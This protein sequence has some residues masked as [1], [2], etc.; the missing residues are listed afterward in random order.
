MPKPLK[1]NVLAPSVVLIL[2]ARSR[3]NMIVR[4]PNGDIQYWVET[5]D[6]SVEAVNGGI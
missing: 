4:G 6:G 2:S 5:S 1:S 3:E